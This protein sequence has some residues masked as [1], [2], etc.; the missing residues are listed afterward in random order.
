VS[1]FAL[2]KPD[3]LIS[4]NSNKREF[5]EFAKDIEG[6]WWETISPNE[7]SAISFTVIVPDPV[8]NTIRMKGTAYKKDCE[9][10][11]DWETIATCL[12]PDQKKV[13]YYWSGL[14]SDRPSENYQG[15]G[16]ITFNKEGELVDRGNGFFS[17]TN[18][19]DLSG[20]VKKSSRWRRCSSE[21]AA[22]MK[23]EDVQKI[24]ELLRAKIG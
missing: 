5:L 2:K 17:D 15:F 22:I 9:L 1:L 11:A 3:A 18:L 6:Y 19:T 21:D 4:S 24:V 12:N 13:F 16:E 10:G 7:S 14:Y 8:R 23:G 20:T